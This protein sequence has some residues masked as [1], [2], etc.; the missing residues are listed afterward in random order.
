MRIPFG[1]GCRTINL[2]IGYKIYSFCGSFI[3]RESFA[4]AGQAKYVPCTRQK[5]F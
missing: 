1:H 5:I 3:L 4:G 2:C